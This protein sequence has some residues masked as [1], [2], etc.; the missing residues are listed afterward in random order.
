MPFSPVKYAAIINSF[1]RNDLLREALEKLEENGGP[2]LHAVVFDA[3]STD[4]SLQCA[5]DF[6]AKDP[7]RRR[8]VTP[9]PGE[10]TSF[11]HG[12][13]SAAE[14]ALSAWPD[15]EGLFLY[16][17]DNLL[18]DGNALQQAERLLAARPDVAAVGFTVTRADGRDTSWGAGRP[19][20][21][22]F[23]VGQ[24]LSARFGLE[25]PLPEAWQECDGVIFRHA[26]I[27]YTSPLLVRAS[28]W[29]E[30]GPLDDRSFPFSECDVE[31]CLRVRQ[32]GWTICVIK[33]AGVVHDNRSVES[34]WSAKRTLTFHRAR[35]RLLRQLYGNLPY[36]ILPLLW[37]RHLIEALLLGVG[38]VFRPSWA[39]R[40][41]ARLTLLRASVTAYR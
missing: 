32:N 15:L 41:L 10:D 34:Q 11:A 30:N 7:Q 12:V 22:A 9:K 16:E 26:E 38:S 4:G 28:A 37:V 24:Q 20:L 13:N 1:N 36:A 25:E 14:I 35:F 31:W 40:F 39:P 17:T 3:G 19:T 8:L 5:A 18:L 33:T 23:I 21:V 6:V 27:V 29:R 2:S